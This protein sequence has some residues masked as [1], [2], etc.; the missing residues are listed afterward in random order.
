MYEL[1]TLLRIPQFTQQT[2]NCIQAKYTSV[3][4]HLVQ[5]YP[6]FFI[7]HF[8]LFPSVFLFHSV[9]SDRTEP[10]YHHSLFLTRYISIFQSAFPMKKLHLPGWS[11]EELSLRYRFCSPDI[12]YNNFPRLSHY[13]RFF[14]PLTLPESGSDLSV[15]HF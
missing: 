6:C 3:F 15:L 11:T 9:F 13:R 7:G 4:R 12:S 14:P 10:S 8:L 1:Q 5:I 2:S